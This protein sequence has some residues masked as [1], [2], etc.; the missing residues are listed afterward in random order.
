MPDPFTFDESKIIFHELARGSFA[1]LYPAPKGVP[2]QQY[3]WGGTI[4]KQSLEQSRERVKNRECPTER[5]RNNVD[6]MRK[7]FDAHVASLTA[8]QKLQWLA[9][10]QQENTDVQTHP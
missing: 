7:E 8:H 5:Y 6:R 10:A 9:A 2:R 3:F 1:M 4:E